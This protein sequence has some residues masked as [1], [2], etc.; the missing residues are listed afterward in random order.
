MRWEY[1]E[2]VASRNVSIG[3]CTDCLPVGRR[4]APVLTLRVPLS[5]TIREDWMINRLNNLHVPSG[6]TPLT[7]I[8]PILAT[9]VTPNAD[10]EPLFCRRPLL[11][12]DLSLS[13]LSLAFPYR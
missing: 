5:F 11:S 7:L 4:V 13:L 6:A 9:I 3:C 12:L 2:T 1:F 8:Y 10:S